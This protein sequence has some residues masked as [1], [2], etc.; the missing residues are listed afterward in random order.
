[1]KR[2]VQKRRDGKIWCGVEIL[3]D[4]IEGRGVFPST[5]SRT[6]NVTGDLLMEIYSISEKHSA[7]R[8]NS[9]LL[10][11]IGVGMLL[12]RGLGSV[13]ARIWAR[14][15]YDNRG[16]DTISPMRAAEIGSCVYN[17]KRNLFI[18]RLARRVKTFAFE[19]IPTPMCS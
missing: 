15:L 16:R 8:A 4:H 6:R 14:E 17:R 12:R 5:C 7:L 9:F 3:F 13:T 11:T 10:R 1:M 18:G 2:S 19:I